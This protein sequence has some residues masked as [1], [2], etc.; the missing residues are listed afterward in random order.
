[1][2]EEKLGWI[3][4][5]TCEFTG[6]MT[7]QA[8]ISSLK[9]CEKYVRGICPEY[10]A[11]SYKPDRDLTNVYWY[12]HTDEDNRA[13]TEG[14]VVLCGRRGYVTGAEAKELQW[15]KNVG[16]GVFIV[17]GTDFCLF[18]PPTKL[19]LRHIDHPSDGC[20]AR[21]LTPAYRALCL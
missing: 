19:C 7:M 8:W 18:F 14:I 2:D 17:D 1:M 5:V 12:Y 3:L 20:H 13:R 16:A 10:D 4:L 6:R 15:V 11:M 9:D 21:R